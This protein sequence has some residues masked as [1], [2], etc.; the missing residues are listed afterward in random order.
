MGYG[1]GSSD[2]TMVMIG[3]GPFT[4]DKDRGKCRDDIAYR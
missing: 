3:D 2:S 1:L 4:A